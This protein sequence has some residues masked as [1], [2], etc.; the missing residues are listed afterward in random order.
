MLV[1]APVGGYNAARGLAGSA[2][3]AW[4]YPHLAGRTARQRRGAHSRRWS[5]SLQVS[6]VIR[7]KNEA[8]FIGQTLEAVFG[9]SGIDSLEVLV[10]DSG[11]TD[12]TLDLVA[13]FPVQLIQIP[14]ESFTYGRALNFGIQAARGPYVVSLS[15]HSLPADP[16]WLVNL[17]RSFSQPLVAG[18]FGRQI[19]RSNATILE[20]AGMWMSGVTGREARLRSDHPMFSN[21]NSAFR[22]SLWLTTPFDETVRG[23]EDLAW[24]R[25]VQSQGYLIAYEPAAAVFHSHGEPLARHLRRTLRDLPTVAAALIGFGQQVGARKRKPRP[26]PR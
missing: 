23:G 13:R 21:A 16:F 9:Q 15:A 6:V 2:S 22:R 17:L 3:Q 10:V 26:L 7:A 20:L 19:P 4:R 1:A 12:S 24:A 14:P 25:T 8:G 11:S 18:V 5:R